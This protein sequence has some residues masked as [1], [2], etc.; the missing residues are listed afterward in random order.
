MH[1]KR[2]G[3]LPHC[4]LSVTAYLSHSMGVY[5]NSNKHTFELSWVGLYLVN[6]F[7]VVTKRSDACSCFVWDD[8][9]GGECHF[10]VF[11]PSLK[12]VVSMRAR[13][14]LD[15]LYI[16]LSPAMP[17]SVSH[18]LETH[19]HRIAT[20]DAPESF[21]IGGGATTKVEN[22]TLFKNTFIDDEL[23]PEWFPIQHTRRTQ[24]IHT[25]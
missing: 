9:V 12:L 1:T 14:A 23:C 4:I 7:V 15:S 24:T 3:K 13:S 21:G 18:S 17:A 5:D 6:S 20:M 10:Y 2:S 16:S 22:G 8:A 11:S 19:K 25:V